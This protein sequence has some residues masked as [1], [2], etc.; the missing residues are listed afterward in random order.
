MERILRM[1]LGQK[2]SLHNII[3]GF[4]DMGLPHIV[5]TMDPPLVNPQHGNFYHTLQP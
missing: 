3:M 5:E 4:G 1:S 2:G